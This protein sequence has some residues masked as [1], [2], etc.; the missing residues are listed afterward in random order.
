MYF[1][2]IQTAHH[3]GL[4]RQGVLQEE[5]S[6]WYFFS[7]LHT[8]SNISSQTVFI[9]KSHLRKIL[10]LIVTTTTMHTNSCA[11]AMR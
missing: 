8:G 6:L 11:P 2:V 3:G 9:K 7:N 10:I 5:N 4:R 1:L